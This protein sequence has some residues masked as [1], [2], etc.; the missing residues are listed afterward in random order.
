VFARLTKTLGGVVRQSDDDDDV[1]MEIF[2][3][4]NWCILNKNELPIKF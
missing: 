4:E 1:G 2:C 3:S